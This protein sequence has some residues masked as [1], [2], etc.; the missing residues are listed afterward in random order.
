MSS[1]NRFSKSWQASDD[2]CW[3]W[4]GRLSD[5]GYG[6]F[7]DS[8][9][10]RHVKAHRWSYESSVGAIPEGLEIDHL[11]RNRACVNPDHLEPVTHA[12]NVRRAQ[13]LK[14]TCVA[15]HPLPAV[16]SGKRECSEC[17]R[18]WKRAYKAR[19]KAKR[20]PKEKKLPP[21][22]RGRYAHHGCRCEI[23][24]EAENAYKRAWR[25]KK[26]SDLYQSITNGA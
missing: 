8:A 21:H 11:C 12:E 9:S 17:A 19:Q 20:P 18:A 1:D 6:W 2:G 7:W 24:C 25:K 3:E 15:G 26:N 14:T 23:C 10:K 22:G 4:R 5:K 13:Y 16:E